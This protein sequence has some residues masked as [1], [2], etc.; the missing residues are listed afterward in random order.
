MSSIDYQWWAFQEGA[1]AQS[2]KAMGSAQEGGFQAITSMS[3][4]QCDQ[5]RYG[6]WIFTGGGYGAPTQSERMLSA[7]KELGMLLIK[8]CPDHPA[9]IKNH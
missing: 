6:V 9:F 8:C 2:E 4:P 1:G 3:C 7:T 5:A